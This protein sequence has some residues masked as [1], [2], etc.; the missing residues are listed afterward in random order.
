MLESFNK[1][2]VIGRFSDLSRLLTNVPSRRRSCDSEI[3]QPLKDLQQRLCSG[4][5][6]DSLD[7]DC[8]AKLDIFFHSPNNYTKKMI[9]SNECGEFREGRESREIKE[10]RALREFKENR[11]FK[12]HH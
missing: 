12:E 5:S 2:C 4:F 8:V 7:S 1:I 3:I 9:D 6:P 10:G 11:E